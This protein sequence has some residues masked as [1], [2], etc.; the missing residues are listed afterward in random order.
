MLRYGYGA[1]RTTVASAL[2]F[3]IFHTILL[4]Y[5]SLRLRRQ[6]ASMLAWFRLIN[7]SWH[8]VSAASQATS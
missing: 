2:N 6:H 8:A 3:Y 4:Y 1:A 5:V 7:F